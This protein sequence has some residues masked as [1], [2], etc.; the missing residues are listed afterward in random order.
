MPI[1]DIIS[2]FNLTPA[3]ASAVH[4]IEAA[5]IGTADELD[6]AIEVFSDLTPD[7]STYEQVLM[8]LDLA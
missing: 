5:I 1:Q 3:Q 7:F 8:W 4:A 6:A 2:T